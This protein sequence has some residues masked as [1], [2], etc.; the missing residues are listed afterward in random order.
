[1]IIFYR[2]SVRKFSFTGSTAVGKLLAAKCSNTVKR[3]SL[4]LGG[5]APFIVFDDADIDVS[6]HICACSSDQGNF[7][8]L[9]L[10]QIF[11]QQYY[12][13]LCCQAAI[14]GLLGAKFRNTGQ[15]CVC[16]NR[17]YVQVIVAYNVLVWLLHHHHGVRAN[18]FSLRRECTLARCSMPRKTFTTSSHRSLA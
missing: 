17:I 8:F 5:N 16:A 6:M 3:V 2:Q 1:M 18:I 14:T 7:L 11:K 12:L 15:T 4:E 13:H 10:L 9:L